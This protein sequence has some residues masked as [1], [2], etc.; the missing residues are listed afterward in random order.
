MRCRLAHRKPAGAWPSNSKPAGI[1]STS[2]GFRAIPLKYACPGA[3]ITT[4]TSVASGASTPRE[5]TAAALSPRLA[6]SPGLGTARTIVV[7]KR[8]G[9]T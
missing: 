7:S 5:R 4:T 2:P 9:W 8:P 6:A 1:T 3:S